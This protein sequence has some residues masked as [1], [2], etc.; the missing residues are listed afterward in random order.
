MGKRI[1]ETKILNAAGLI[2]PRSGFS[3]TTLGVSNAKTFR[4][5]APPVITSFT[6]TRAFLGGEFAPR[7][8]TIALTGTDLICGVTADVE[9]GDG[10]SAGP[11]LCNNQIVS[12]TLTVTKTAPVGPRKVT[13][14][15]PN[16]TA[17]PIFIDIVPVPPIIGSVTP[18]YGVPG[19][20]NI[21]TVQATQTTGGTVRVSGGG[22]TSTTLSTS[23]SGSSLTASLDI[24]LNTA[25]GVRE[26]TV[27]TSNGTSDPV[28]F[29]I[30]PPTWPD[31]T[32]SISPPPALGAGYDETYPIT[33][34][35]VGAKETTAPITVTFKLLLTEKFVSVTGGW[36]CTVSNVLTCVTADSI[37]AGSETTFQLVT[38]APTGISGKTFDPTVTS[39]EDYNTSNN[40]DFK[41]S[42]ITDAP[43]PN[44]LLSSQ[45]LQPGQQGTVSWT[46]NRLFPHDIDDAENMLELTF[47]PTVPGTPM[48]PAAQFSS[49]GQKVHYI[50]RA[51]TL[52]AEFPGV[53]GQLG[54]QTGTLA[55]TLFVTTN[56]KPK[57]RPLV[58]RTY[59]V[60]VAARAPTI[61]AIATT[62]LSSGFESAITLFASTKDVTSLSFRF[63]TTT[64]IQ[65]SCGGLS[66]CSAS[67]S[68]I[69]F[70]VA[71]LFNTWYADN[72]AYGSLATIRVPFNIQGTLSG[73][74]SVTLTNALGPS[75]SMNF[76][77][78]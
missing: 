30:T 62:K 70:T 26:L 61:T 50:F 14:R 27:T 41:S 78:P 76:T 39:I 73:S 2:Y 32:I 20:T 46:I 21:I 34:R 65:L 5:A 43:Q 18:P 29:T 45:S 48:D 22:I 3:S 57:G 66:G 55:G 25:P 15:G 10:V 51:N 9:G 24:P 28:P 4:V 69:T 23:P 74:I 33:V 12:F 59:A 35:N 1:G 38:T 19:A 64:P 68:T 17:N 52:T 37:A 13:V 56:F 53:S 58:T 75:N 54:F 47:V 16:G 11:G 31:L 60:S 36:T 7:Q 44:L 67:G 77:I 40:S 49:G 63:N 71:S 42:Q 8:T 72:T 6:P